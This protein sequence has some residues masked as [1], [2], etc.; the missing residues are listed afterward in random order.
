MHEKEK[1]SLQQK[2]SGPA[3]ETETTTNKAFWTR[4]IDKPETIITALVS[5]LAVIVSIVGIVTSS[6][7]ATMTAS[8]MKEQ[9][10]AVKEQNEAQH[11]AAKE[12]IESQRAADRNN[13]FTHAIEH[14]KDKSL[15]IRMGALYELK[16][17]GQ[18]DEGLQEIIVRILNP[19]IREGIE[20]IENKKLLLPP[21]SIHDFPRPNEDVFVACEIA[22]LF[23]EQS[24]CHITLWNLNAAG[25]NLNYIHL[26]G[27]DL[28]GA[29]LQGT[30]LWEAQL[31]ETNLSQA[32]LQSAYLFRA[33]LQ[34]ASLFHAQLFN[35]VIGSAELAATNLQDANLT[36]AQLLEAEVD[37]TTLLAPDLRAEYDRLKAEQSE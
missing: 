36:V 25:L 22:S 4:L 21:I 28:L 12:Q 2:E 31:Q 13:R 5:L 14:L 32:Q 19:F 37:D 8:I 24:N 35:A 20:G 9:N 1:V 10:E 23:Y 6:K 16:K 3:I 29:Q 34:K 30:L 26:K 27:A 17:L 11:A 18:E 33:Q 15:A 7:T